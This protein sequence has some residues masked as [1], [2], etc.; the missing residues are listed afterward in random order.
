[1]YFSN[2]DHELKLTLYRYINSCND[3]ESLEN[4]LNKILNNIHQIDEFKKEVNS[5]IEELYN[6]LQLYYQANYKMILSLERKKDY[7]KNKIFYYIKIIK[8]Y[9]I[10][11]AKAVNILY[12]VY[13]GTERHLAFKRIELLKKQYP[14]IEYITNIK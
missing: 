12:E 10:P 11:N 2:Y 14:L 13:T 3:I 9:D 6:K 8:I 7:Y 5:Y 4:H 1:M